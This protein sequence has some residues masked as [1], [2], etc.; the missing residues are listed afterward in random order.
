MTNLLRI[1]KYTGSKADRL[2]IIRVRGDW[3]SYEVYKKQNGGH[4]TLLHS[5]VQVFAAVLLKKSSVIS[6]EQLASFNSK[7][8]YTSLFNS[9]LFDMQ[10]AVVM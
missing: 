6:M 2:K 3:G 10:L 4:C 1:R 7:D 9:N 5:A 8:L